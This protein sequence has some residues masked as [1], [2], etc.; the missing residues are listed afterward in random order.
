M[1]VNEVDLSDFFDSGGFGPTDTFTSLMNFISEKVFG[2][3]GLEQFTQFI[4]ANQS[5]IFGE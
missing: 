5:E 1:K 4:I 3:T 2:F